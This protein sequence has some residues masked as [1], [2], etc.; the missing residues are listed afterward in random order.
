MADQGSFRA[1]FETLVETNT[2][3]GTGSC[4]IAAGKVSAAMIAAGFPQG[5]IHP[6]AAPGHPDEGGIMAVLRGSDRAA[7]AVLFVA[8]I[9]TVPARREDWKSDPFVLT[10]DKGVFHGR[11]VSDNKAM[12]AA[13]ADGL[14]GLYAEGLRPR[15]SIGVALTCG[16]ETATALNGSEYLATARRDLLNGALGHIGLVLIPSGGGLS[17]AAGRKVSLAIQAGEKIQQ[18]FRIEA[19]GVATHASRPA[20]GNAIYILADALARLQHHSFP[21]TFNPTTRLYFD[22]TAKTALPGDAKAIR[23]LLADPADAAAQRVVTANTAWNAMARTT[24]TATVL[25]SGVQF[26]TV[27]PRAAANVNCRLL[28]GARVADVQATLES[29]IGASVAGSGVAGA[30]RLRVVAV[31][32]LAKTTPSPPI[33][34]DVLDPIAAV[35]AQI[36]PGVPIVP[37]MLTGATDARHFN[38]AGIP[39]FGVTAFFYDADGNGVHAPDERAGVAAVYEGREFIYRLMKRYASR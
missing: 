5:D 39:A 6:Y 8:H 17:D 2:V 7:E 38:A 31:P 28:P 30:G 24:C 18:N 25:E 32:P 19:S 35:A 21:V 9:D 26:N 11:G 29:V 16:E 27:S 23:R 13:L 34:R 15:R 36:W 37:T 10:E 22:A 20:P 3:L 1:L 33:T 12:A 4:T 14:V